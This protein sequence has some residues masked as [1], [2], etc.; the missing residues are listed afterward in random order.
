MDLPSHEIQLSNPCFHMFMLNMQTQ[1]AR[2]VLLC[3]LNLSGMLHLEFHLE[4]FDNLCAVSCHHSLHLM[5]LTW[6]ALILSRGV[7]DKMIIDMSM[8]A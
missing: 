1:F 6:R 4:M 2:S 3:L 7:N 8:T 5:L